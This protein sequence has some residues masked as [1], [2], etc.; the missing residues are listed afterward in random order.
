MKCCK[1]CH[2]NLPLSSFTKRKS[3]KDGYRNEC[4]SC[5]AFLNK[6]KYYAP[7]S[8]RS[9]CISCF[10]DKNLDRQRVH[11]S[12]CSACYREQER[13]RKL[14][15]SSRM[16]LSCNTST[17][18]KWYSGPTC[19]C[20]FRNFQYIKNKMQNSQRYKIDRLKNN[21]RSR[22]SKIVNGVVKH[23]SAIEDLGCSLEDLK[24]Y[25]QSKFELNMTWDNYGHN[26]WHIDHI[27]PLS[28]FDLENPEEFKKA[29][30]Y[31]NLQPLWAKDNL[32]KSDK[33]LK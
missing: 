29:C 15:D 12:L 14:L 8:N 22:I 19:R 6:Q 32:K 9:P 24:I 21:L 20:C 28:S 4:K 7:K 23:G 2:I 33:W 16:C 5:R 30:H 17:S 18:T 31:T 13:E 1:K 10:A 27:R 26:G 25:I 3:A 11:K